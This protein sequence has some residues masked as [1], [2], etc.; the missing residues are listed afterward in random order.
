MKKTLN[1]LGIVVAWILSIV[2]VLMLLVTP[3][4]FSAL[5]LLNGQ[6]IAKVVTD[7]FT[8]GQE[9]RSS[10]ESVEIVTLSNTT[11]SAA[12]EDVGKDMLTGMFGDSV[13]QEQ[14]GA[15]MSSNAVK[16]LIEAYT[17]DL[18][19]AITGSNQ[20]AQFN[21]EKLKS[22]VNDN[23]DDIVQ[24]LQ[25]NIPECANMDV[26]ELRSTI[27][28]A[29]NENAEQIVS[30]LP[31][32]EEVKEQLIQSNPAMEMALEILS[33]KNTIKLAI[34]G[35]VVV[36]SG[37]IFVCRIPGMRGFRWLAVN[38]FVG[39]G[40]NLLTTVG[41]FVSKTAV[42]EIA[43]EAGAQAASLIGSLL[44]SFTNGMLVRT[45][46]MLASGGALL[47]A[48]ILIKKQKEKKLAAAA[49][50]EEIPAEIAAVEE[51][52][53]EEEITEEVQA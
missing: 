25:T 7:V 2:L 13:S 12:A 33:M 20:Q 19:N 28:K 17:G 15:I 8:V 52:S 45:L 29:V 24:V 39:G 23:I 22:I 49:I 32:P 21:A 48:Y 43:K 50:L 40:L 6:T 34:I 44:S 35:V 41:L 10:A 27:L 30:A 3:I 36:L 46:V 47:T 38:L 9:A 1:V 18:T 53:I 37:L 5:S 16:E 14:I 31:K 51:A 11:Q 42:S 4:V 26:A